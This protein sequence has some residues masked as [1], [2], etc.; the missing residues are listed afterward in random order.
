MLQHRERTDSG[1]HFIGNLYFHTH[2]PTARFRIWFRAYTI[3][4]MCGRSVVSIWATKRP[5]HGP[6]YVTAM[7][8][9]ACG[10]SAVARCG[11]IVI[12]NRLDCLDCSFSVVGFVVCRRLIGFT[13]QTECFQAIESS[14]TATHRRVTWRYIVSSPICPCSSS[15]KFSFER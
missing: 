12:D 10:R 13:I 3:Y 11:K 8:I 6:C 2:A 1:D 15:S 14:L 4:K 9:V 7:T 5:V